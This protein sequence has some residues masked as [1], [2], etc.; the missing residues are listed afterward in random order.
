M[1]VQVTLH[2]AMSEEPRPNYQAFPVTPWSLIGRATQAG[3]EEGK[4]SL[5]E[6]LKR[7]LPALRTHLIYAKRMTPD[8]ADDLLQSFMADKIVEQGLVGSANRAQGKFRTFLLTAL[9]RFHVS[10]IRKA[11][12][13]KR[14]PEQ[15]MVSYE[16]YHV[17]AASARPERNF[18]VAWAREIV[19]EATRRTQQECEAAG[20]NDVWQ[21]LKGRILDPALAGVEPLSYNELV[22]RLGLRS[23]LHV[24]NLLVTGRRMYARNLRAVIAEYV[25]DEQEIEEEMRDLKSILSEAVL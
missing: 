10:Q 6:L 24:S 21:L 22:Q 5:N 11:Q 25:R 1:K 7:Y 16:E 13:Q 17:P 18:E 4:I 19:A 15:G 14:T 3:R 9:G 8:E 2:P 12:T 23:P 20:H